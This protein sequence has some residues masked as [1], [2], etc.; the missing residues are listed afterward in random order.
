MFSAKRREDVGAILQG[1]RLLEGIPAAHRLEVSLNQKTDQLAND[2]DVIVY[3]EFDD[4]AALAAFK[5]HSLYQQAI[6]IVRPLRDLRVA[7][8]YKV[9]EVELT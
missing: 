9:S 1:L 8:D 3:G 2:I 4:D 6:A 5:A 7:A